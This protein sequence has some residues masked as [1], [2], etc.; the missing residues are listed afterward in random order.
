MVNKIGQS[1][2]LTPYDCSPTQPELDSKSNVLFHVE[3]KKK[4]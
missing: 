4:L 3:G 2:T 1:G